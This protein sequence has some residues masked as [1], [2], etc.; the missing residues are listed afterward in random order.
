M[1]IALKLP[2]ICSCLGVVGLYAPPRDLQM[3][4]GT[5]HK[6][7][8]KKCA[9]L[10]KLCNQENAAQDTASRARLLLSSF[11]NRKATTTTPFIFSLVLPGTVE[12]QMTADSWPRAE[13]DRGFSPKPRRRDDR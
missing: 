3:D 4:H 12:Q 11:S 10:N 5:T 8:N 9:R 7:P 2:R 13:W 1:D 6:T